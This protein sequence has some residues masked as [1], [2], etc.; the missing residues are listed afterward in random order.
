MERHTDQWTISLPHPLSVLA[1]RTAKRECRT[2]SELIREAL[3]RYL[4]RESSFAKAR[5]KLANRFQGQG[6]R[7]LED[8][9]RLVHEVRA[10]KPSR[11]S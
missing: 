2:R 10:E 7:T 5:R 6:I 11:R 9:D 4:E 8:V 1:L 3:R